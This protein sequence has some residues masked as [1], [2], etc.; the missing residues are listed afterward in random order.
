MIH[1]HLHVQ[2]PQNIILPVVVLVLFFFY[3]SSGLTL[4]EC[5]TL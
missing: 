5:S 4:N 1:V 3:N 2:P